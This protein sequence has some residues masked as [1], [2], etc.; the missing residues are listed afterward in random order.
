MEDLLRSSLKTIKKELKTDLLVLIA[1][2]MKDPQEKV[3][4]RRILNLNTLIGDMSAVQVKRKRKKEL[5][6]SK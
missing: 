5:M 2:G 1:Q 6:L 4:E 3:S